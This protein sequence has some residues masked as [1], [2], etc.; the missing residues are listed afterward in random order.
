MDAAQLAEWQEKY[1]DAVQ[2]QVSEPVEAAWAFYRS[3][4]FAAMGVRSISPI[5]AWGMKALSKRKAGGLPQNFLLAV[6][7]TRVYAFEHRSTPSAVNVGAQLAVWERSG[8]RVTSEAAQINTTVTLE[9]VGEVEK[10]VCSTGKDEASLAMIRA[11]QTPVA[12]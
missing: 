8:L 11:L 6:T 5:A 10:V 1:R 4:S 7:P 2:P 9:S 3:G 12:A